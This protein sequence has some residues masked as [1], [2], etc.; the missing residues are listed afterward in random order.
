MPVGGQSSESHPIDVNN[1]NNNNNNN[2]C[3]RAGITESD[4]NSL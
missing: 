3:S 2:I 4:I 1:N